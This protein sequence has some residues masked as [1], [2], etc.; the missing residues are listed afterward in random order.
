M[1]A[2]MWVPVCML[3]S[4][5]T[6]L[7]RSRWWVVISVTLIDANC[8]QVGMRSPQGCVRSTTLIWARGYAILGSMAW[9]SYLTHLECSACGAR[10]DA[11]QPQTVCTAC[12]LVLFARYDLASVRRTMKPADFAG[13]RWDMWRYWELL[14]V[15][16]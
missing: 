2:S 7:L 5:S 1:G 13:R 14:P 16:D 12:G 6:V 3:V 4:T 15:R 9:R 8:G 10:H 11:D